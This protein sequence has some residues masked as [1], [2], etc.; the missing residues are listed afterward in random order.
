MMCSACAAHGQCVGD[1]RAV[2]T[3]GN[4]LRAHHCD[5]PLRGQCVELGQTALEVVGEHVVGVA[6]EARVLPAGVRRVLACPAQ[7]AEQWEMN[8]PKV[9]TRKG[10]A[11]R[12]AVEL[13]IVA[14]AW[15]RPDV[16]H[17]RHLRCTKEVDELVQRPR[18]VADRVEADASPGPRPRGGVTLWLS[19]V[20]CPALPRARCRAG[21]LSNGRWQRRHFLRGGT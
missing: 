6:P 21:A 9:A 20:R 3:P 5:R 18:G 17:D 10:R 11:E 19:R 8:V 14:R 13:R 2:A 16:D 7:A 4:R 15:N 1:Q 12:L